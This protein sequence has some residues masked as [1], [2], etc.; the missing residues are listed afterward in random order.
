MS[1]VESEL[2]KK[3]FELARNHSEFESFTERESKFTPLNPEAFNELRESAVRIDQ[4]YLSQLGE[5]FSLRLRRE[6]TPDGDVFVVSVKGPEVIV[7][8][9]KERIEVPA[10]IGKET[11][12][13]Y[14]EYFDSLPKV[15]QYRASITTN[16]TIDF[17]EGKTDP[18][19]EPETNDPTE[20]KILHDS[21]EG[22]AINRTGD[23]TLSKEY[24]ANELQ[25]TEKDQYSPEPLE[26]LAQRIAQEAVLYYKLY[27]KQIVVTVKGM[28]GS[29]KT[30]LTK[31]IQENVAEELGIEHEPI[32]ISTDDYHKGKQAIEKTYGAPWTEWDD[33]R[34]Y[35]TAELAFNLQQ[36]AEG[37]PLIRR[38]FDFN[39]EEPVLDEIV[40]PTP[41]VIIEGLYADSK[42]LD[43]VRTLHYEL[44]TGM[45]TSVGRDIQRIIIEGRANEAYPTPAD[46]LKYQVEVAIPT[47]LKNKRNIRNS[48]SASTR[49]VP[50]MNT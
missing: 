41:I 19:I 24:I 11:Y 6:Y 30:T 31:M 14:I 38:H 33:P 10:H 32:A 17:I 39:T 16:M 37:T 42:D 44:P 28:S 23:P 48:F 46:R 49:T 36:L 12:D 3:N 4:Y 45:A 35:N 25:G 1:L 2:T 34:V 13:F 8:G 18:I 7:D 50:S 20:R 43:E 27:K 40:D 21:L 5:D 47:Y 29:G 15:T 26:N 9:V 22:I